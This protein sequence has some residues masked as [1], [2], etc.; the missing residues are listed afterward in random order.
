MNH[1]P[2]NPSRKRAFTSPYVDTVSIAMSATRDIYGRRPT[3]SSA[4]RT[5]D[6]ILAM[7]HAPGHLPGVTDALAAAPAGSIGAAI[8]GFIEGWVVAQPVVARRTY[9]RAIMFL[10]IDLVQ[11][12]PA[13]DQPRALLDR[14]RLE[15]HLRWRLQRGLTNR[16]ELVRATVHLARLAAWIGA[17]DEVADTVTREELR[18][19]IDGPRP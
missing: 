19:V 1:H 3:S 5:H 12:G 2:A 4:G 15:Q 10:V 11:E 13:P 16:Y 8:Q 14:E 6:R 18:A 9:E 7:Q 17:L